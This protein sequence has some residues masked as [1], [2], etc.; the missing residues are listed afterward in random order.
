MC[1]IIG[2]VGRRPA[3]P[4]IMQGLR[5]LK[6]RGYD[7]SGIAFIEN[8]VMRIIKCRGGLERL[9][10]LLGDAGDDSGIA[11][12]HT[13]WATHG[14]PSNLNAHP[15]SDCSGRLA[16]V[17]NGIIENYL[18]L[19]AELSE[20]GHSFKSETDTEVFIHLIEE[21]YKGNLEEALRRA[22]RRIEGSYAVIVMIKDN[23]AELLAL[24]HESPIVIG[25]GDGE[26]YIASDIP[27]L[28]TETWRIMIPEDGEVA[29]IG[30]DFVEIRDFEGSE[31]SREVVEV[32]WD[33]SIIDKGGYPHYML[34]EIH[35]QAGAVR[36]TLAELMD[37]DAGKIPIHEIAVLE[38]FASG[39]GKAYLI[40]AGSAYHAC[41]IGGEYI[42]RLAGIAAV[43]SPASE[44][45]YRSISA[46]KDDLLIAVSQSG[47]TADTLRAIDEAR[48]EG[49]EVIAL[50]N[51]S[52]S[53]ITREVEDTLLSW[54]GPEIAVA[55]TKS[56][57]SQL[58]LLYMLALMLGSRRGILGTERVKQMIEWVRMIPQQIDA[59]IE[60]VEEPVR[61]LAGLLKDKESL[62]LIGGGS[63]FAIAMEGALK[64][65]EVPYI[66]AEAIPAGELKHGPLA[67]VTEEMPVIALATQSYTK[68]RMAGSIREVGARGAKIAAIVREGER[69]QPFSPDFV[70]SIPDADD[71]LM[72]ILSVIPL[73]MLAYYLSVEKGFNPDKPRNLAKSVTVE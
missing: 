16:I 9:E 10:E 26:N 24:R 51:T 53:T 32:D 73:Q 39:V 43:A 50:T 3:V 61:E 12:G 64:L 62:F 45:R 14:A 49:L 59:A 20:N 67:L 5:R 28:L 13:R 30:R 44:Y 17:H 31:I 37:A 40:G 8:E 55:S 57:T 60:R 6:Y 35:D 11:I 72:P 56:F 4:I 41:V 36:D 15:H 48:R 71:L 68:R 66:H 23:P 33:P 38:S 27:A 29:H 52:G 2:Y 69:N 70:I 54:A 42:E 47:E 65:K 19:R 63:D 25:L 58:A 1:G 34:K 46:G 18:T 21:Y 7:S 22:C